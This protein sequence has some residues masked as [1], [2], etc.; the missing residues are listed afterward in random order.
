MP[1]S[2]RNEIRGVAGGYLKIAIKAPPE[3]GKANE[4]LI[5]FLSQ[6]LKIPRGEISIVSGLKSRRKEIL[7][8]ASEDILNLIKV[9]S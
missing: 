7:L 1:K 8:K 6:K 3:K 2:S 4:E 9:G 5:K